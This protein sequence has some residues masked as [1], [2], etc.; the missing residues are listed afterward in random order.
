[1]AGNIP[2]SAEAGK[3]PTSNGLGSQMALAKCTQI[4]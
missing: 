1:M 3:I 4:T 2:L